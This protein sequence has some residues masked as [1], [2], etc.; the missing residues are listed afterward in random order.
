MITIDC[1]GSCKWRKTDGECLHRVLNYGAHGKPKS[2]I[3]WVP[4]D[5]GCIY[6]NSKTGVKIKTQSNLAL[7]LAW[8]C[9]TLAVLDQLIA[10]IQKIRKL[11]RRL[12]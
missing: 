12:K 6:W 10:G 4:P 8:D 11:L 2:V 7:S 3:Y 9:F 1:C 5:F